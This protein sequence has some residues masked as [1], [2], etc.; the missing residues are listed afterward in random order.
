MCIYN[1]LYIYIN[2]HS[3][4]VLRSMWEEF[5]PICKT[6]SR[7]HGPVKR[8][9]FVFCFFFTYHIQLV[10]YPM[11]FSRVYPQLCLHL[12]L[13]P[14]HVSALQRAAT[15]WQRAGEFAANACAT[16]LLWCLGL[17]ISAREGDRCGETW[18]KLGDVAALFSTHQ[19]CY[20]LSTVDG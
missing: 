3:S 12:F 9:R 11:M 15:R 13:V 18:V 2:K 1:S 14:F 19:Y 6:N 20:H 16:E 17:W 7:P 10:V 5:V 8:T 4:S